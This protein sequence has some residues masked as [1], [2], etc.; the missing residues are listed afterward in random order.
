MNALD[1]EV[2]GLCGRLCGS[3]DGSESWMT[4][5]VQLRTWG[6][7]DSYVRERVYCKFTGDSEYFE[8]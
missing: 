5:D 6:V 3:Y 8:V 2:D 4:L 7:Q 1:L